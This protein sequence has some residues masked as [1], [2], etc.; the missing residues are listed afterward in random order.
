MI[1]FLITLQ[2]GSARTGSAFSLVALL[3]QDPKRAKML[4]ESRKDPGGWLVFWTG[5]GPEMWAYFCSVEFCLFVSVIFCRVDDLFQSIYGFL[6]NLG[7][8]FWVSLVAGHVTANP[9]FVHL[10]T[11]I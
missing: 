6:G 1:Y 7:V 10:S 4:G 9:F 2:R 8:C 5:P 3:Q 11:C